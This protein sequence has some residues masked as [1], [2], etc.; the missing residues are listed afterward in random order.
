MLSCSN[1]LIPFS[2]SMFPQTGI[3]LAHFVAAS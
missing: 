1:L 3:A 2:I